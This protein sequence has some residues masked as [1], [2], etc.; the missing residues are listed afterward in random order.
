MAE[1]QLMDLAD[2]YRFVATCV[3]CGYRASVSPAA[4]LTAFDE[5]KYWTRYEVA[6][7]LR[8]KRCKT[9]LLE[10]VSGEPSLAVLNRRLALE[11]RSAKTS[12]FQGGMLFR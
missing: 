3:S 9:K 5:A 7:R 6:R 1:L 4:L 12:A 8:C 2:G 11:L 10:G